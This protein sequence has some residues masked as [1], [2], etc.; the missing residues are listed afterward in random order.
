M[1]DFVFYYAGM[2]YHPEQ[3]F[4]LGFTCTNIQDIGKVGIIDV[5]HTGIDPKDK[6]YY[7]Q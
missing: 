1:T 7:H 6:I 5:N 2:I 4:C 3:L